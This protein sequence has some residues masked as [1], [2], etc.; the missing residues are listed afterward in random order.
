MNGVEDLKLGSV[1]PPATVITGAAG[2]AGRTLAQRLAEAGHRLLLVGRDEPA[3]RA[4]AA[5][6]PAVRHGAHAVFAVDLNTPGAGTQAAAAAQRELGQVTGL[7][8]LACPA[9]RNESGAPGAAYLESMLR[10]NA[11][12]F[13]E[14][15]D[16]LLPSMLE[17]QQGT[18]VGLLTEAMRPPGVDSWPSYVIAK[19]ALLGA[20]N[21]FAQRCRATGVRTLGIAPGAL[22]YPD[23]PL[24]EGL[25]RDKQHRL[26]PQLLAAAV[27]EDLDNPRS[28]PNGYFHL[29][30]E[31]LDLRGPMATLTSPP[32]PARETSPAAPSTAL[33]TQDDE[34]FEVLAAAFRNALGLDPNDDV[35]HCNMQNVSR[36]DSIG[37]LKLMMEVEQALQ[38]RLDAGAIGHI[39]SFADLEHAVRQ[40]A[41]ASN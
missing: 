20:L 21:V 15:A 3:L 31:A 12:A 29:I 32:P 30:T 33:G 7:L 34:L 35:R 25:S 28:T 19:T 10:V 6:L 11:L 27:L 40:V 13:V 22:D 2:R 23:N 4:L 18:L 41:P 36:W 14:L 37:H 39:Q 26:D 24:P 9:I 16:A 8:H 17:A 5:K 1:S 38:V